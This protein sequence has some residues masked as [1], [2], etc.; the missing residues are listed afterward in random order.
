MIQIRFTPPDE[1]DISGTARELEEVRLRLESIE[2]AEVQEVRMPADGECDPSPYCRALLHLYAS[3]GP[4]PVRVSVSGS[5][6]QAIGT[7]S[8]L[9]ALASFFVFTEV[10]VPG[11]HHHHRHYEGNEW[12]HPASIQLVVGIPPSAG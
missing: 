2:K 9:G 1:L 3:V 7:R 6:L 12:I 5:T 11:S 4:D 10:D 8:S